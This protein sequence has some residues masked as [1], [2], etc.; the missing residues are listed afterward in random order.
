M[1]IDTV[2]ETIRSFNCGF[3]I[4][5]NE[6]ERSNSDEM[7]II[8]SAFQD[9]LSGMELSQYMGERKNIGIIVNDRNR[10]TKT[11]LVLEYLMKTSPKTIE[12]AHIIIATGTHVEPTEEDI[13][14][15]L[16]STYDSN[17]HRCHIHRSRNDDEHTRLGITS[18]GTEVH[19]DSIVNYMDYLIM[20]NSV[21]PHYFA[22]FT[23][24]RKSILPGI[25]SFKTI[26][27]NH[28]MALNEGSRTIALE[29]NPV[30]EDMDEAAR[31]FMKGRDHLSVQLIQSSGDMLS[32]VIIG[33]LFESFFNAVEESKRSFCT[34]IDRL[35]DIVIT[36][37]KSPMDRTLYQA[38]KALEHGKLALSEGGSIILVASCKDGIGQSTFWELLNSSR[39]PGGVL[40][41]IEKGYK[42]GYHKAAR[43]AQLAG[44]S[45]IYLV[46]DLDPLEVKKGFMI[47]YRSFSEAFSKTLDDHGINSQ[48]A[49]IPDGCVTVPEIRK[50]GRE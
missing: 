36:I 14:T 11:S 6:L 7:D 18:K 50:K 13:M 8:S 20:I 3:D 15:I 9:L 35:Y 39:E 34:P 40:E 17:R 32:K 41:T 28:S 19:L 1:D 45:K 21:E 33:D 43:I 29:G 42:L 22:G 30:H 5:N 4:L 25:A 16:G 47:G 49:I 37:A 48:I 46:S 23:G 44:T 12:K 24:G 31:L 38:Q 10:S 26:E 2:Y 27:K